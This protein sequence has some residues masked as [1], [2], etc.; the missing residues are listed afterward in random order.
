MG[1]RSQVRSPVRNT[2]DSVDEERDMT[3]TYNADGYRIL[4]REEFER[5]EEA[6]KAARREK[7]PPY[8]DFI[9]ERHRLYLAKKRGKPAPWT[10]DPILQIYKF[11]NVYRELDAVS[12]D[13]AER[14]LDQYY[15]WR[16]SRAAGLVGDVIGYRLFNWPATWTRLAPARDPWNEA[17]AKRILHRAY[18]AG[19]KVFTGAYKV[20][21]NGERRSKID[22]VCEAV[23][24]GYELAPMLVREI[25]KDRT[26]A[27]AARL[28]Q[29]HIPLVGPFVAY[30]FACD[31]RWTKLLENAPDIDTWGNPG[32]GATRGLNRLAERKLT[33]KPS[34]WQL[35]NEMR[36]ILEESRLPGR[37]GK[38]M[39]PL[40]MRDVEHSLCEYDKY[41]RVKNGEGKP[42]SLYYPKGHPK[43]K[44]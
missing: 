42:R 3:F 20:S 7:Y 30:E 26:L 34:K 1:S 33:A 28:F 14:V 8:F 9:N 6:E 38:H 4:T 31:L 5:E 39:V 17:K 2:F 32:P 40:E 13:C 19:H 37:L 22:L 11:T 43:R 25:R 23:S 41:C 12:I 16:K 15:P 24:V 44:D 36:D 10:R 18:N 27:N 29:E 35:V 21:N